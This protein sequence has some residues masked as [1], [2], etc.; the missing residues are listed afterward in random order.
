MG[1]K[2]EAA[3]AFASATGHRCVIGALDHLPA[4]LAGASG[5]RVGVD[6]IGLKFR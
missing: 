3:A 2:A 6:E 1:P 4:I 5:T